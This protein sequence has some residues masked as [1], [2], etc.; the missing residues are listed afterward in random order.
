M[1]YSNYES[2]NP[3]RDATEQKW[4]ISL[5]IV[6]PQQ[7]SVKLV[8]GKTFPYVSRFGIGSDDAVVI[9]KQYA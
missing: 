8:S 5:G 1:N 9:G 3:T 6:T 2:V 7:V 4:C